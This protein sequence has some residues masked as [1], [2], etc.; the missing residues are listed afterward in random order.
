MFFSVFSQNGFEVYHTYQIP[1]LSL[2]FEM[3]HSLIEELKI[4][5]DGSGKLYYDEPGTTKEKMAKPQS[6]ATRKRAQTPGSSWIE[7]CC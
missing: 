6:A 3:A 2:K 1:E 7:S 4:I 5:N